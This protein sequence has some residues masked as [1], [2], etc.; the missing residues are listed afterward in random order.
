ME[1]LSL[2]SEEKLSLSKV[3]RLLFGGDGD[4]WIISGIGD[5]FPWPSDSKR[6][7]SF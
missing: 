3:K 1:E 4:S 6:S 2:L 7:P 5:Y